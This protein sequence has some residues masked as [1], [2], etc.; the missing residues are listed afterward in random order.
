[1]FSRDFNDQVDHLD[2][3]HTQVGS[4]TL[5][6]KDSKCVLF[7][8]KVSFLGHTL[9]KEGILLDPENV[10]RILNWLV[11]RTVHDV[12]HILGMGSYYYHFIWVFSDRLLP[13]IALTKKD[14]PFHWTKE[15]QPLM[16]L[17]KP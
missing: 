11:P 6:L 3:V 13:L 14:K 15:C 12:R 16:T 10:T 5:N 17:N 8:T 2:K 9:S 4:A 1:M 7:S